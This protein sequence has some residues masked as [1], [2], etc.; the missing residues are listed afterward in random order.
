[1]YGCVSICMAADFLPGMKPIG[2]IPMKPIGFIG[3]E[4]NWFHRSANYG[5]P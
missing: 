2:F 4:T 5:K 3:Y 1:M